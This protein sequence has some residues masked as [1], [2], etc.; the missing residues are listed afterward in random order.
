[1][2]PTDMTKIEN[3]MQYQVT[4]KSVEELILTLPEV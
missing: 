4:L 3:E 1:M 2:G